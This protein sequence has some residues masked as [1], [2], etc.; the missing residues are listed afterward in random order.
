MRSPRDRVQTEEKGSG[1]RAPYDIQGWKDEQESENEAEGTAKQGGELGK[2]GI[3]L[4][5]DRKGFEKLTY[6]LCQ[7]LSN[8]LKTEHWLL[9]LAC[10]VLSVECKRE[11]KLK[12]GSCNSGQAGGGC[13]FWSLSKF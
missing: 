7:I 8:K 13:E 12:V 9:V 11:Q 1:D 10:G 2:S 6:H 5:K 3:Q 4:A